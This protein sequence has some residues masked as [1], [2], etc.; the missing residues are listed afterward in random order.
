[1]K[2]NDVLK[3]LP[4]SKFDKDKALGYQRQIQK[5]QQVLLKSEWSRIKKEIK[6]GRVLTKKEVEE[7]YIEK[8]RDLGV[9]LS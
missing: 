9:E 3:L 4:S 6:E 2:M 7:V 5:L 1:K 8:A